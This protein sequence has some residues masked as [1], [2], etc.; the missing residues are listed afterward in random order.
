MR[1]G[2]GH[3][4]A[5]TDSSMDDGDSADGSSVKPAVWWCVGGVRPGGIMF[6]AI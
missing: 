6:L 1:L 3:D 4:E 2:W 5:I